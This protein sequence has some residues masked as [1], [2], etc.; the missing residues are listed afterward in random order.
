MKK[1]MLFL[2]VFVII[3]TGCSNEKTSDFNLNEA[4]KVKLRLNQ[5]QTSKDGIRYTINL[6][7]GSDFTLKQNDVF[8]SFPIKIKG[9]QKGNEF[10]I[11]AKGNKLN[12]KPGEEVRLNAFL[13]FDGIDRNRLLVDDPQVEI[14]GYGNKLDGQHLFNATHPLQ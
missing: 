5:T 2:L 1:F 4:K 12:I 13:P 9:G 11:L 14:L 3:L 6:I 7:N 10:K 8:V